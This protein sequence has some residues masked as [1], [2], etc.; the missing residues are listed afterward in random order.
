MQ[1]LVPILRE[2]ERQGHDGQLTTAPQLSQEAKQEFARI[3]KFLEAY[4]ANRSELASR[5]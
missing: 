2:L 5:A 3:C 1:R 4:L